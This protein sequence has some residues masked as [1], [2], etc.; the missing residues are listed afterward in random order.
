MHVTEEQEEDC[1]SEEESDDWH[2]GWDVVKLMPRE[3]ESPA[4]QWT[5]MMLIAWCRDNT[6][7]C[8]LNCTTQIGRG[9]KGVFLN[10]SSD[11]S[12]FEVFSETR[13]RDLTHQVP[14]SWLKKHGP[15]TTSRE[16]Q[17]KLAGPIAR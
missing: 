3:F 16:R 12:I 17:P 7:T 14:R 2:R 13:S 9:F 10:I 5:M 15:M 8:W 6:V 1:E 4:C 11:F